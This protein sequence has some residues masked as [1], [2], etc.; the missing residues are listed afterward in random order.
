MAYRVTSDLGIFDFFR[1]RA[2]S[3]GLKDSRRASAPPQDQAADAAAQLPPTRPTAASLPPPAPTSKPPAAP[4]ASPLPVLPTS[5]DSVTTTASVESSNNNNDHLSDD[6]SDSDSDDDDGVSVSS[7]ASSGGVGGAISKYEIVKELGRGA[8]AV[9]QLGRLRGGD[10]L[11]ALKVFKTSLL[12]KMREVKRVGRRMV[13]STALDKVQ[14]EI[15][16]MK[17]LHHPN[18]LN[19]LEVFDDDSDTLV[20]MLEYAPSGQVM[21]WHPEQ[22]LYKRT[23]SKDQASTAS[24][25]CFDE[26]ELRRC[27]RQLLL[28][29]EYL[30]ENN[31]CHRDLKPENILVGQDGTFKIADFGVAH[32]FEEDEKDAKTKAADEQ[33]TPHKKGYVSS[34]AGTY[35]FMGPETLKGGAYSAY[36]ADIW[37][38][39]ITVHALAFGTIPFYDTDVMALFEQIEKQPIVLEASADNNSMDGNSGASEGLTEL[40]YG[41]LEK[42]PEKRW[43]LKQCKQHPWVLEGLSDVEKRQYVET[44]YEAVTVG[45]ED[46]AS[47]V[48]RMT[49][50]SVV[51]RVK[52]GANRWKR[53]A[54]RTLED[55][56]RSLQDG[57]SS[58]ASLSS[59]FSANGSL[60]SDAPEADDTETKQPNYS[61]GNHANGSHQPSRRL[62]S[63]DDGS[64]FNSS[65]DYSRYSRGSDAGR[66]YA[67]LLPGDGNGGY[68]QPLGGRYGRPQPPQRHHHH[69]RSSSDSSTPLVAAADEVDEEDQ[70][71]LQLL[72]YRMIYMLQGAFMGLL[73]PALVFFS[74]L[75]MQESGLNAPI[76]GFGPIFAA[77]GGAALV[78]SFMS[79]L[80]LTFAIEKD[81]MKQLIVALLLASGAWYACLTPIAAATGNLGVGLYFIA[82]GFWTALLNIA[83]VLLSLLNRCCLWVAG[84]KIERGRSLVTSMNV[85]Y[86]LG[87]VLGACV[88]LVLSKLDL[89][90]GYAFFGLAI[91]TA[92]P[93]VLIAM[94]PS[95]RSFYGRDEHQTL[96]NFE[97]PTR[98]V[99]TVPSPI[100]GGVF[101]HVKHIGRSANLNPDTYDSKNNFIILL[102]TIFSTVLFGIQLGLGAFLYDYIGHVLL[103]SFSFS[104]SSS[105]AGDQEDQAFWQ[106]AI[107]VVFWGALTASYAFFSRYMFHAKN[108]YSILVFSVVCWL[109]SFGIL[110]GA[111]TGLVTFTIC[112]FLFAF[113]LAPLFTLSIHCLTRVI[114]ELLIR[115]V[116]SLIVFGC[117]MGEVFIPVLMGFFMSGQSGQTNGSVA[118]SYITFIL[119]MSLVG[120]SGM[121][122][123]MVKARL[124]ELPQEPVDELE[125]SGAIGRM[126]ATRA[127]RGVRKNDRY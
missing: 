36:A 68:Q 28:G 86:G 15:A 106:C 8:T 74:A 64:S 81:F 25:D 34:T 99:P 82:K 88:A 83:C 103:V 4:S 80:V 77:H 35:A 121:L 57:G 24:G 12:R 72:A 110:F 46:L 75:A 52:L 101:L 11:V 51:L 49:S 105:A 109:S 123:W 120:V 70:Y 102:V 92:F 113:A 23:T 122:L 47:A 16:I 79:E 69:P 27:V 32:F 55:R 10:E 62:Y 95:P 65:T 31:I 124:K 22:R 71:A 19:L 29:L 114:N 116:S 118:V 98:R 54:M 90:M 2:A 119:A 44:D 18:L 115:R 93:A 111:E 125:T 126:R 58:E 66:D 96:L 53:K 33:K 78:M 76:Y 7:S 39:G 48:T 26:E 42:D 3:F 59:R 9:V 89:D 84:E 104:G 61:A 107:M 87:C 21:Q 43:T 117:G 94:L 108:L 112:I 17:K 127:A 14:V 45:P 38:L 63:G 37:A 50:L 20:L 91:A 60:T 13:V 5:L 67:S 40:L 97:D 6:D 85:H 73:G 30:H 100:V 41:L 56:R 1:G